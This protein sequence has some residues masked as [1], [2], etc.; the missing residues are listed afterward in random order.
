MYVIYGQKTKGDTLDKY[1]LNAQIR[2]LSD[3]FQNRCWMFAVPGHMSRG[4]KVKDYINEFNGLVTEFS[5]NEQYIA[6]GN[7]YGAKTGRNEYSEEINSNAGLGL[8]NYDVCLPSANRSNHAKM[9]F[10]FEWENPSLEEKYK[11]KDICLSDK[12][13]KELLDNVIVRA[14]IAGSSNQSFHTYFK[15]SADKGEADILLVSSKTEFKKEISTKEEFISDIEGPL[16]NRDMG[17]TFVT[18]HMDFFESNIISKTLFRLE[19]FKS[20]EAFLNDIFRKCLE[21]EL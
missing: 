10:Y 15:A 19:G 14:V 4:E 7:G 3:L 12:T 5:N 18:R 20:E 13:Y 1:P 8:K 21:S 16:D 2:F 11:A 6:F 9:L 17:H